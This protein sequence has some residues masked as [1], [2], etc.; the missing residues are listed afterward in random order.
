MRI[1]MLRGLSWLGL[2]LALLGPA[3]R[4]ALAQTCPEDRRIAIVSL[5]FTIDLPGSYY[6]EKDLTGVPMQDGITIAASDVTLD[7]M[8]RS[9]IGVPGSRDGVHVDGPRSG[10]AIRNGIIRNWGQDGVDAWQAS[11]SRMTG[12]QL[13]GNEGTGL[14]GGNEAI[15]EDCTAW[16]NWAGFSVNGSTITRCLAIR[17]DNDG[18]R[19][20]GSSIIQASVASDN[21]GDG[22]LL[23]TGATI[24]DSTASGNVLSGIQ[25]STVISWVGEILASP[26][27]VIHCVVRQNKFSGIWV[28][29]GST[30]LDSVVT[31]NASGIM[32]WPGPP[33]IG[34]NP[35]GNGIIR[36]CSVRSNG[37]GGIIIY[38]TAGGGVSI[39]NNSCTGNSGSG[40][41][42]QQGNNRIEGNNVV[43]NS[44]GIQVSGLANLIIRNSAKGNAMGNYSIVAGNSAGPI[45]TS[46]TIGTS[47]NPHANYSF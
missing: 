7:L 19:A 40:I 20:Y 1:T 29:V 45:V 22:F 37:A 10:I 6:L 9:L 31:D 33:A 17:N 47:T 27:S 38:G 2:G 13:S 18:I 28:G 21:G 5:P 26:I 14:D 15:V 25:G 11:G 3:G 32:V 43:G 24:I 42:V 30:V 35:P 34:V 39:L 44:T 16:D 23:G 46:A 36:G 4:A 12:L 41:S 8:G